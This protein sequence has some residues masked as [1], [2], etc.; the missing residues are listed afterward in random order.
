MIDIDNI[1]EILLH[2]RYREF[3]A[4]CTACGRQVEP[5]AFPWNLMG[6]ADEEVL[7]EMT[8]F[9]D[10]RP[11][12]DEAKRNMLSV[13]RHQERLVCDWWRWWGGWEWIAK[14]TRPAPQYIDDQMAQAEAARANRQPAPGMLF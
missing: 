1:H 11:M 12:P 5:D 4:D 6:K 13:V 10:G 8:V 14:S 7:G 9:S 3:A 2:P